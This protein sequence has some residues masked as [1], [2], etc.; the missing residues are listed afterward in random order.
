M[1]FSKF[2]TA[3]RRAYAFYLQKECNASFREIADKCGV[4]KSSAQRIC[5]HLELKSKKC[6]QLKT[7]RP[8]KIQERAERLLIRTLKKIRATNVNFTVKQLVRESGMT[9][10][11]ASQRTF[12]RCL[13]KNG[14]YYLQ[15]RKKGLL[16]ERDKRQRLKYARQM[17][18]HSSSNPNFWTDDVGFYLDGISFVYK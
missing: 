7:G 18:R 13:N 10:Q 3:E 14:Y 1:V 2:I 5:G 4:S 16:S 15:A 17:K 8:R 12:S 6:V 9:L 11:Q